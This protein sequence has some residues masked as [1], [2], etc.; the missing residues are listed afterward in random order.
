[1]YPSLLSW[2]CFLKVLKVGQIY[3]W[4]DKGFLFLKKRKYALAPILFCL[5]FPHDCYKASA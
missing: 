3:E 2:E 5:L 1:M 4:D